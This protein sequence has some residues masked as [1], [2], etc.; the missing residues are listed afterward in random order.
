MRWQVAYMV[1]FEVFVDCFWYFVI[2]VFLVIQVIV[3]ERAR[4]SELTMHMIL[5]MV[6]Y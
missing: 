5:L 6:S 1:C 2:V 4:F 3:Y